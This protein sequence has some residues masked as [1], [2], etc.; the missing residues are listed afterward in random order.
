MTGDSGEGPEREGRSP[1][2]PGRDQVERAIWGLPLLRKDT[3][4]DKT[5]AHDRAIA[6][7]TTKDSK[8]PCTRATRTLSPGAPGTAPGLVCP[9]RPVWRPDL[10][11]TGLDSVSDGC[12]GSGHLP[13]RW[14][15]TVRA[16]G[17]TTS[18][19][20]AHAV[21]RPSAAGT[22]IAGELEPKPG[23][24]PRGVI[25]WPRSTL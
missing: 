19:S 18:R 9:Q 7:M 17:P 14:P 1:S 6:T 13:W 5:K 23:A 25:S 3:E 21:A 24:L 8:R 16:T 20:C 4:T 22:G 10:G 11:S 15:A 12:R 2:A